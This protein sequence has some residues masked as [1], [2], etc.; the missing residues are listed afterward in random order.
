[1]SFSLGVLYLETL[2]ECIEKKITF[3]FGWDVSLPFSSNYS[4][5]LNLSMNGSEHL[6]SYHKEK[7]RFKIILKIHISESI[8]L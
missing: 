1:M 6:T 5:Q 2:R 3:N 4:K 7:R 8:T